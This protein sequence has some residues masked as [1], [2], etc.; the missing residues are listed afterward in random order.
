MILNL[1]FTTKSEIKKLM[2]D[3]DDRLNNTLVIDEDGFA[4]IIQD[5][6]LTKFYPVVSETWGS[7]NVY[8][9]R[10]S[11]LSDLD[12]AYHYCLGKWLLYLK[13]KVGQHMDDYDD[14]YMSEEELINEIE[15]VNNSD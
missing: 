13:S 6:N 4:H 11:T 3:A 10:Y 7:R 12:S 15:N 5:K 9:G 14:N 8:V 2:R 1:L